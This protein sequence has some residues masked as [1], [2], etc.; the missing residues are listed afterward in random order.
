MS[1]IIFMEAGDDTLVSAMIGFKN[2]S[3]GID[4][5][6]GSS[7]LNGGE[8]FDTYSKRLCNYRR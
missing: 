6:K 8:G 4:Y 1:I 7:Y 3:A 2:E 5:S